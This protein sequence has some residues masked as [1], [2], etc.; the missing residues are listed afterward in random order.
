[1]LEQSEHVH[2][3]VVRDQ[4][5]VGAHFSSSGSVFAVNNTPS[6]SLRISTAMYYRAGEDLANFSLRHS[7]FLRHF[8][9]VK[10]Y[11]MLFR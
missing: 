3:F 4:R 6:E 5:L 7:L 9:K 8:E 2:H 10:V 1:M 11:R